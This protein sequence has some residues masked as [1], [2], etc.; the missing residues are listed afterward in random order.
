MGDKEG[1]TFITMSGAMV[2]VRAF[3]QVS[4][5][6]SNVLDVDADC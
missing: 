3:D 5:S 4:D 1:R 6:W 2:T